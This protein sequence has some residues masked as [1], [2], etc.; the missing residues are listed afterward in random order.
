MGVAFAVEAMARSK[1]EM[2]RQRFIGAV[3]IS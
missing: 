1:E 3:E 2:R